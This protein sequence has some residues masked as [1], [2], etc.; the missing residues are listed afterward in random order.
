MKLRIFVYFMLAAM[1]ML[2]SCNDSGK[3]SDKDD[4]SVEESDKKSD[5][6][7]DSDDKSDKKSAKNND[8]VDIIETLSN[9]I[10]QKSDDWDKDDW[11]DAADTF[12]DAVSNLP[13][14]MTND[15]QTIVESAISRMK[16]YAE[17][18]RRK[19][20]D[21]LE[22]LEKY[23]PAKADDASQADAKADDIPQADAAPA[24]PVA[25]QPVA[26]Q[27]VAPPPAAAPPVA[28][29]LSAH[30]IQE[31]GYT[32][33]RQGPGNNYNIVTKVKDGSPI[34]YTT[35][36]NQW[37][38]VYNTSGQ[39]L[40]YMHTSKVIPSGTAAPRATTSR[41]AT[42]TQYDWLASRYVTES[43][44]RY[45]NASQLRILRNA[46]YA[47]HYY[48]FK[49][50]A[51]LQYFNS[52]QWYDGRRAEIPASEFNKYEQYNINFI[53]SHE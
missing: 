35:Y 13:D 19:A 26:P 31:G 18:H 20:T 9:D 30:V 2:V 4:D 14:P 15:E 40:G 10:S 53:K 52:M 41:V 12:E 3:K 39:Y 23:K 25:P 5:K 46:I 43:D 8:P 32:N 45:L 33:V 22:E 24:Q 50:A 37:H 6:D 49:D 38:K 36:N 44:L 21:L 47:R 11:E 34:Y 27:P 48:R 51:L 17:R 28:G 42:G 16:V 7:D 29:L 1:L